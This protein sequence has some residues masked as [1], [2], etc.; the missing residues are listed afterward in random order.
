L[1][2]TIFAHHELDLV[3]RLVGAFLHLA[4]DLLD[5]VFR[6]RSRAVLG[7]PDEAGDLVGVLDQV[8]GVVVHDHFDQHIAGEKAA[9]GGA[10]RWPFFISTTSSVGTRMRPNLSCMPARLMRS[11]MLR[12][13]A[14]SMPE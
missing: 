8:P 4:D 7:A 11:V 13:T 3:A 10:L 12:S 9:L 5:F 6:D 2:R 14:F 1:T